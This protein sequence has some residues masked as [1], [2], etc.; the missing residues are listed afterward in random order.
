MK[1]V[2]VFSL[3]L[4]LCGCAG[5]FQ[6]ARFDTGKWEVTGNSINGVVYYEPQLVKVTYEYTSLVDNNGKY[7]GTYKEHKC[8]KVIQKE[9]LAIYPNY[10]EPRVI[11]YEPA[12]LASNDFSVNINNGM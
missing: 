1:K 11:L 5:K 8:R 10:G 4:G 2:I 6:T 9:E 12:L 3:I 7:I